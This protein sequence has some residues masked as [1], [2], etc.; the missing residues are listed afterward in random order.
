MFFTKKKEKEFIRRMDCFEVILKR[1]DQES[2]Y[3]DILKSEFFNEI[4]KRIDSVES[5]LRVLESSDSLL[6]SI[7]DHKNSKTGKNSLS[8][9]FKK[10]AINAMNAEGIFDIKDL[11]TRSVDDMSRLIRIDK[12]NAAFIKNFLRN[13]YK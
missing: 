5:R 10:R 13:K 11:L 2:V 9:Y 12:A 6:K 1:L 8:Y 4:T 3:F 7:E